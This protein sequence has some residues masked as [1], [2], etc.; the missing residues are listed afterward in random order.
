MKVTREELLAIMD[1]A[2]VS[3]DLANIKG[4][5]P[6]GKAGVDSLEMMNVFL[7]IEEKLGIK[8]PDEEAD[9]MNT[10]DQILAYLQGR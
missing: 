3:A 8:I 1:G 4:D 5:T 6:L 2:G 9:A 10:V 7:A